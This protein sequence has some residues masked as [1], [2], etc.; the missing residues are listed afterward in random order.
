MGCVT[1]GPRVNIWGSG[2]KP[3]RKPHILCTIGLL[4]VQLKSTWLVKKGILIPTKQEILI[5]TLCYNVV[6]CYI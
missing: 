1:Q 4:T 3:T 5:K 6:C 2:E